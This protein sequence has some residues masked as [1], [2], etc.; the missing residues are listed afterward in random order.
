[1]INVKQLG[2]YTIN[3]ID[4]AVINAIN[5]NQKLRPTCLHKSLAILNAFCEATD[6]NLT[7]LD[8]NR[9]SYVQNIV[10]ATIGFIYIEIQATELQKYG[11]AK[12]FKIAIKNLFE[13]VSLPQPKL[14]KIAV[15]RVTSEVQKCIQ[16]YNHDFCQNKERI[17]YYQGWQV[18]SNLGEISWVNL[19]NC[20]TTYGVSFTNEIHNKLKILATRENKV[21]FGQKLVCFHYLLETFI[22]M[23]K[24]LDDFNK[25]MT[26]QNIHF[27]VS[28]AFNIQLLK[29]KL[30]NHSIK[31]FHNKWLKEINMF[32][33]VFIGT[34][35]VEEPIIE[36]F[37][38]KYK[39]SGGE[40]ITEKTKL[41]YDKKGNVFNTNLITHVP[42]SYTDDETKEEIFKAI[43]DDIKHVIYH[44]TESMNHIMQYYTSY[45]ELKIKGTI[46]KKTIVT[47][48]NKVSSNSVKYTLDENVCATF[49]HYLWDPPVIGQ[50]YERFINN[51]N[52]TLNELNKL[53]CLPTVDILIPLIILLIKEHPAITV[54]WLESWNLYDNKD[55]LIGYRTTNKT[56]IIQSYKARR[57]HRKAQQ[58]ITL[59]EKS[60]TIVENIIKLTSTARRYLKDKKNKDYQA[61]LIC[62]KSIRVQPKRISNKALIIPESLKEKILT[63]STFRSSEQASSIVQS[64][65]LRN[66]RSS[67]ALQVYFN[68]NS[69]LAMSES[70]GHD[71]Y[72][73]ELI[74]HYLPTQLWNYFTHRWIRIFQNSIVYEAM[75]E[76]PYL[77]D[78]IDITEEELN[79]FL[80]NHGLG[81]ISK[82]LT[83]GKKLVEES[84]V[85][86]NEKFDQS[87]VMVSTTLF[88]V[89]FAI[90]EIVET[91][92][93]EIITKTS[94]EWYEI[95]KYVL[96]QI[97]SE[98]NN[99]DINCNQ[100]ISKEI[101][102]MYCKAQNDPLNLKTIEGSIIC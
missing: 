87:V 95:S 52:R 18:K 54:S 47:I 41:K 67:C 29:A 4:P 46:R 28:Q 84:P 34:G 53:I 2:K 79:R 77:F 74:N 40:Q 58:I 101:I 91:H 21:N 1:M 36:L 70:L 20:Y 12:D 50:G 62:T 89:M 100:L 63:P 33:Q 98:L 24:T 56:Q 3:R 80:K 43:Q 9:S 69:V 72:S 38:P 35:L 57:G 7:Y 96:S 32:K 75:Q 60:K 6:T 68:T 16:C 86:Y 61:M 99:K 66:M 64:L 83:D 88:K 44:C 26:A 22:H 30:E 51:K 49:D 81:E 59:N 13:K 65:T 93:T 17:R 85:N 39:S 45:E 48:G 8:L 37:I 42:L 90:I 15:H 55:R 5:D 92:S 94:R 73:P 25:G 14:A 11:Y 10:D 82:C 71:K 31:S 27:S 76:S 78:A 97:S 23:F 102:D 19:K